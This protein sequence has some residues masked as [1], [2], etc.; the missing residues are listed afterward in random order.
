[1]QKHWPKK[2]LANLKRYRQVRSL[3]LKD[4]FSEEEKERVR[5]ILNST[6]QIL[7][8]IASRLSSIQQK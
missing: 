5:I 2:L 3:L 1:M 8:A 6:Q 7:N 4:E